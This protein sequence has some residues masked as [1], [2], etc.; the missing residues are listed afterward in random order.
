MFVILLVFLIAWS[1]EVWNLEFT[2]G[3]FVEEVG[4]GDGNR[5]AIRHGAPSDDWGDPTI[6]CPIRGPCE[7]LERVMGIEPT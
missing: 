2:S 5:L 3:T 1:L 7:K 4:A 6:I